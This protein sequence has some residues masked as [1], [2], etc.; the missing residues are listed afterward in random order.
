MGIHED[1]AKMS[2]RDFR[3][4]EQRRTSVIFV[5]E[6]EDPSAKEISGAERVV[7]WWAAVMEGSEQ[8]R[9]I[10]LEDDNGVFAELRKDRI[11]PGSLRFHTKMFDPGA[12]AFLKPLGSDTW[13]CI[14]GPKK[15]LK[16]AFEFIGCSIG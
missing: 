2:D 1:P 12:S 3:E 7:L 10:C 8:V 9:S 11:T 6:V 13:M 14:A 15:Q 5:A 16:T 4:F